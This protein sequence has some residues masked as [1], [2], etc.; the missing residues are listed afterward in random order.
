MAEDIT[1]HLRGFEAETYFPHQLRRTA[2]EAREEIERL[3]ADRAALIAWGHRIQS[4]ASAMANLA[5]WLAEDASQ[6]A[7]A[8]HDTATVFAPDALKE[9]RRG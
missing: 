4:Q 1:D 6:Q 2:R 5:P 8:L 9:A 7:L 3:R